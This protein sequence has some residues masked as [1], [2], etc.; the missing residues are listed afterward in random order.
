MGEEIVE[1]NLHILLESVN[2]LTTGLIEFIDNINSNREA[3]LG[4]GVC[5]Q[6]FDAL[7]ASEDDPLT[8]AGDVRN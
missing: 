7:N 6:L 2:H 5:H 4:F 3:G 1:Y 8:G